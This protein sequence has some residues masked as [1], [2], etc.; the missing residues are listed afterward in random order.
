MAGAGQE[1]CVSS[2]APARGATVPRR[3]DASVLDV[4]SHAP[5]RG[6]TFAIC[7][8]MLIGV[9]F[10]PRAREGRDKRLHFQVQ[11]SKSFKP[12]AREGRDQRRWLS[13]T[14]LTSFK[15]RAREGRD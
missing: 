8:C 11:I 6:A 10:K 14:A 4:S 9:S 13:A 7:G 3:E 2:H 5:A 12:R 1:P 15:P